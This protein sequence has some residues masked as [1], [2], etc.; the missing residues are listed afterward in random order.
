MACGEADWLFDGLFEDYDDV[1]DNV[2]FGYQIAHETEKA[3]LFR[4]AINMFWAPKSVVASIG[5]KGEIQIE[6]WFQPRYLP[7]PATAQEDFAE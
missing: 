4:S 6:G 1:D 7:L 2:Y 3:Y 5:L